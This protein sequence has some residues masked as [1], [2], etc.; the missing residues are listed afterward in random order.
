MTGDLAQ[1]HQ[2]FKAERNNLASASIQQAAEA[3]TIAVDLAELFKPEEQAILKDIEARLAGLKASYPS[4]S[5]VS[6]NGAMTGGRVSGVYKNTSRP[7]CAATTV[8]GRTPGRRCTIPA[9]D[10]KTFC[11]KHKQFEAA[12]A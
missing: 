1:R 5:T 2:A 10:G 4:S 11:H 7:Q 9:I 12:G 8:G 3:V 6:T